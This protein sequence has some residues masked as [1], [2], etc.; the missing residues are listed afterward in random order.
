MGFFYDC[1]DLGCNKLIVMFLGSLESGKLR[2][3]T[4]V[5]KHQ[6]GGEQGF[7]F[8]KHT[9]IWIYDWDQEII[10]GIKSYGPSFLFP[11][12]LNLCFMYLFIYFI[13]FLFFFVFL[14]WKLVLSK[15]LTWHLLRYNFSSPNFIGPLTKILI[16]AHKLFWAP[17]NISN[18]LHI[19][20]QYYYPT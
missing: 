19:Y 18:K 9:R 14:N 4:W 8:C 16:Q 11:L 2:V 12:L 7:R 1:E 6:F 17:T 13:I 10:V 20:F 5:L 3:V 15:F